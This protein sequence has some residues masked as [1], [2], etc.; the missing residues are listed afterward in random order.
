MLMAWADG[1]AKGFLKG[2]GKGK[3]QAVCQV[4]GLGGSR[5]AVGLSTCRGCDCM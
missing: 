1:C 3:Q 4:G 2:K 5:M